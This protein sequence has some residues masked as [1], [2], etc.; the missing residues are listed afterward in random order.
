M[1]VVEPNRLAWR[2]SFRVGWLHG[3]I[4]RPRVPELQVVRACKAVSK[5]LLA[6]T[7]S[8]LRCRL[9]SVPIRELR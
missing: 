9:D 7:Q 3:L 1:R 2:E 4:R 8:A 6:V 5:P